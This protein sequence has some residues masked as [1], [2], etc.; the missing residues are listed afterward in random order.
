MST[1]TQEPSLG[2]PQTA[3][4]AEL[5]AQQG[6]PGMVPG[7]VAMPQMQQQGM[8]GMTSGQVAMPQQAPVQQQVAPAQVAMPQMQQPA[9]IPG[10]ME[11]QVGQVGQVANIPTMVQ[12]P[13]MVPNMVP[14]A[15]QQ[16]TFPVIQ[17]NNP[18]AELPNNGNTGILEAAAPNLAQVN[19]NMNPAQGLPQ[20]QQQAPAQYG[21]PQ[22]QAPQMQQAMPQQYQGIPP[23]QAP[24]MQQAMP[25]QAYGQN[26]GQAQY[27]PN[28]GQQAPQTQQQVPGSTAPGY[29]Q[30]SYLQGQGGMFGPTPTGHPEKQKFAAQMQLI[31]AK[32]KVSSKG[33]MYASGLINPN[34]QD[35][36]APASNF[37]CFS[38]SATKQIQ[39][40]EDVS[41]PNFTTLEKAGGQPVWVE[42]SWQWNAQGKPAPSW[43]FMCDNFT[44]MNDQNLR[45][46]AENWVPPVPPSPMDM[47]SGGNVQM[48][49]MMGQGQ[50]PAQGQYNPAAQQAMPQQG[51]PQPAQQQYQMPGQVG[52][53]NPATY[54][55]PQ[56]QY[57]PAAQQMQYPGQQ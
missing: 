48:Q 54:Q 36:N 29:N 52:Q 56:G 6:I 45:Q 43:Q 42:G 35:R 41:R 20:M 5:L 10:Q 15:Q 12:N 4:G 46:I 33:S 26:V 7:Q 31:Y 3:V 55:M 14:Q 23:Q 51:M 24:Q 50:M 21:M 22:Q 13:N 19:M 11:G 17:D 2:V 18:V 37:V 57:N 1:I 53:Y 32:P 47:L 27:N 49:Q 40:L 30:G 28:Y 39:I 8:P 9:E 25:Q 38:G 16:S 44:F 34:P